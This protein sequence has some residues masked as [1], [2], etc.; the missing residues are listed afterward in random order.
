MREQN[1][2]NPNSNNQIKTEYNYINTFNECQISR[3][4]IMVNEG[5]ESWS[6][7]VKR[8]VKSTPQ[9]PHYLEKANHKMCW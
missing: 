1:C 8:Q 7:Y 4:H 5:I 6:N 2:S 3:F 9:F